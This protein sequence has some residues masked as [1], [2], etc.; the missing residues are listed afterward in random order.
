[1]L[2]VGGDREAPVVRSG[3]ASVE[4]LVVAGAHFVPQAS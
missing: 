1:M 3:A 4:S 2:P